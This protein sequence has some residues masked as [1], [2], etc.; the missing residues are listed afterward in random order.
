MKADENLIEYLRSNYEEAI[1]KGLRL[2]ADRTGEIT[3]EEK[4]KKKYTFHVPSETC[5]GG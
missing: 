3:I 5:K 4:K 2:F 1:E